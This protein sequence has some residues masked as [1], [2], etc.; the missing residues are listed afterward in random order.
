MA[1]KKEEEK[2]LPQM[3]PK[4]HFDCNKEWWDKIIR[5]EKK[6]SLSYKR[7]LSKSKKS[8]YATN[9]NENLY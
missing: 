6:K 7:T 9:K 5:N 3:V 8:F 2:S 1:E 4:H